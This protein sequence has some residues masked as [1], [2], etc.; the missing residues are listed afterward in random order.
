MHS[1][2]SSLS[3]SSLHG[4]SVGLWHPSSLHPLSYPLPESPSLCL[5]YVL[6]YA[7]IIVKYVVSFFR[8]MCF[9]FTYIFLCNKL[10]F[11]IFLTHYH[12]FGSTTLL[13]MVSTW[14]LTDAE[15]SA[16]FLPPVTHPFSR[17]S[18]ALLPQITSS[19]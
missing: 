10:P 11:P 2:K 18:P 15:F 5:E 9:K 7:C 19:L 16:V 13:C 14:F 4:L 1:A 8:S 17:M 3:S 12:V 6:Q